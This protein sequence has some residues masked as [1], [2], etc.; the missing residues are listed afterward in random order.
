MTF[1]AIHFSP[2]CA[3]TKQLGYSPSHIKPGDIDLSPDLVHDGNTI[4]VEVLDPNAGEIAGALFTKTL[5]TPKPWRM[6]FPWAEPC[7]SPT[8]YPARKVRDWAHFKEELRDSLLDYFLDSIDKTQ[9][10][11]FRRGEID[12]DTFC[13]Q[14]SVN[15]EQKNA[16]MEYL[17]RGAPEMRREPEPVEHKPDGRLENAGAIDESALDERP[18]IMHGVATRGLVTLIIGVGHSGKSTHA[19][20]IGAAIALGKDYGPYRVREQ[21]NVL[22]LNRENDRTEQVLRLGAAVR[23]LGATSTADLGSRLV[24]WHDSRGPLAVREKSAISPGPFDEKLRAKIKEHNIGVV[25]IDPLIDFGSGV[26]ENDNADMHAFARIV[27]RIAI[28][29]NCSVILVHHATKNAIP[30]YNKAARGGSA[31][32]YASRLGLLLRTRRNG[33]VVI[34]HGKWTGTTRL[35]DTVWK[36]AP[37]DLPGGLGMAMDVAAMSV[38]GWPH[39]EALLG[40]IRD[41]GPWPFAFSGKDHDARLDTVAAKRFDVLAEQIRAFMKALEEEGLVKA[42]TGKVP[43]AD[44]GWRETKIWSVVELDDLQAQDEGSE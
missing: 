32:P 10:R 2:R 31:L 37:H 8:D 33:E 35:P 20:G 9:G 12:F 40:M 24:L 18:I 15:R 41:E 36:F 7:E 39:R 14:H 22:L 29:L 38:W 28:E 26:R 23:Q 43:R 19:L 11:Q 27:T 44:K 5:I 16:V 6:A 30:D 1:Y 17:P 34:I 25:I 4:V 42:V 21:C 13:R 3:E